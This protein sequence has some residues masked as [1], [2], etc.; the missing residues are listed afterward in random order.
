MTPTPTTPIAWLN[1][2]LNQPENIT[3][4]KERTAKILGDISPVS[5]LIL[6]V[7]LDHHLTDDL[8]ITSHSVT[9]E[10]S[11][12]VSHS[13]ITVLEHR[14]LIISASEHIPVKGH[15][16]VWRIAP[17]A[18]PKVTAIRDGLARMIL[19]QN[20]QIEIFHRIAELIADIDPAFTLR[21]QTPVSSLDRNTIA[22]IDSA[23]KAFSVSIPDALI[24]RPATVWNLVTHIRKNSPQFSTP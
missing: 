7:L 16:T 14:G 3:A 9:L 6:L 4:P 10:T 2:L 12:Q 21:P 1:W 11:R 22:F 18:V 13:Q 24:I 23:E 8:A 15:V 19:R 20:Q 5:A 17:A